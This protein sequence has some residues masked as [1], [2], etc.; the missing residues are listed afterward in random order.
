MEVWSAAA[1]AL[2]LSVDGLAVGIA[3]GMRGIDVPIRS[4]LIV[5][6]CSALCFSFALVVGRFVAGVVDISTPHLIGSTILIGLGSWHIIKGWTERGF[7]ASK[8]IPGVEPSW[9]TLARVRI[10]ALG[11]VVQVLREPGTADLDR[12]GAI[13]AREALLLGIALGLDATAVGFG[14]AFIGVGFPFVGVVAS[15]Q[16]LLTWVG[17]HAGKRFGSRWL[18]ENGYYVPGLILIL[19]GLLQL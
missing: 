12:S 15:S 6:A 16:L 10:K 13:D 7:V 14:A 19:I 18:G 9:A 1:L 3:Y 2:A 8:N 5:A 11:I 4:L 17:L